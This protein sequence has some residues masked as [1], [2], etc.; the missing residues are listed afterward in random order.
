ML[1]SS[2]HRVQLQVLQQLVCVRDGESGPGTLRGHMKLSCPF[3]AGN[4]VASE[5]C[6]PATSVQRLGPAHGTVA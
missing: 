4:A 2:A 3:A 5:S 1:A 6:S